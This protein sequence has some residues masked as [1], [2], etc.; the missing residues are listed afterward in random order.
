MICPFCQFAAGV[1]GGN[2]GVWRSTAT[3]RRREQGTLALDWHQTA[4]TREHPPRAH[5]AI[6]TAGTREAGAEKAKFEPPSSFE[7]AARRHREHEDKRQKDSTQSTCVEAARRRKERRKD[8][9]QGRKGAKRE[10]EFNTE[11]RRDRGTKGDKAEP[12]T[13]ERYDSLAQN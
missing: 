7:E 5:F 6:C 8:S 2:T 3:F 11:G 10:R 12:P 4:G 9:T 13:P 1:N